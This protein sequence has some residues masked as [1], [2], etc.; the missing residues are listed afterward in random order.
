MM[1]RAILIA[2]A[3]IFSGVASAHQVW[4]ER[5]PE[6]TAKVYHGEPASGVIEKAGGGLDKIDP[7]VF[8]SDK[9]RPLAKRRLDDHIQ[10]DGASTADLRL[11]VDRYPVWKEDNGDHQRAVYYAREGR[12]E[13]RH[14]LELEFTPVEAGS[15]T[16]VLMRNGKPVAGSEVALLAPGGW[17]KTLN[18]DAAGRVTL[19]TPWPGRY[20][21]EAV[22]EDDTKA[23]HEGQQISKTYH[24]STISFTEPG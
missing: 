13:A 8:H 14:A 16:F 2:G 11:V 24:V 12:S 3:L 15:D 21:A 22:L 6:R 1:I 17:S 23:N 7:V 19:D 18:T 5:G 20:I 9:A 4:I 10:V